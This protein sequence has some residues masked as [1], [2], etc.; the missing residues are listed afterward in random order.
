[1]MMLTWI[2]PAFW[3]KGAARRRQRTSLMS[4][5]CARLL[6][7]ARPSKRRGLSGDGVEAYRLYMVLRAYT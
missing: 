2:C 4:T 6:Y 5:S 7:S 1:V 3:E